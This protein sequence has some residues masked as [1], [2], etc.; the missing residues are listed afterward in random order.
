MNRPL[1]RRIELLET[2]FVP[3]WE[4]LIVVV[5]SIPPD[6]GLN[7]GERVVEDEF[8]EAGLCQS[9]RRLLL[10][11]AGK[12]FLSSGG[13]AFHMSAALSLNCGEAIPHLIS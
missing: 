1:Q 12:L 3:A 2:R 10:K 9:V 7:P 13:G 8:L 5:K 11:G 4:P 6:K